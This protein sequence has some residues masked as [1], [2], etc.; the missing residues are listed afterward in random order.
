MTT[1]TG[2]RPLDDRAVGVTSGPTPVSW[3][4]DDACLYALAVGAGVDDLAYTTDDAAGHPHRA[5]PTMATVL[6][7]DLGVLDRAAA[8]DWTRLVHVAHDLTLHQPVVPAG[9]GIATTTVREVWDKRRAAV[10]VV[11]TELT[12]TD[13]TPW[14]T[15]T[16]T[17]VVDGAGGW[18][19]DR[20]PRAE[21]RPFPDVPDRVVEVATRPEQALLYRL[22]G[23]HNPL[24]SDPA[25]ARAAGFDTP[26]LHGL[27]T[28]GSTVRVLLRE[29][30]DDD[31]TRVGSLHCRFAA[32]VTPGDTLAVDVHE[33]PDGLAFRT[34]RGTEPV[35]THGHLTVM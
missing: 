33:T 8:V 19:G 7:V 30:L 21:R 35:L 28:L 4:A 26:I 6:G 24:H 14:T 27:C 2:R 22:T 29:A 12:T 34:R 10:A 17:L 25:T 31:P 32:P 20:G 5:L 1:T 16:A 11:A 23:D 15:S 18:G 9:E 3:T 13:G